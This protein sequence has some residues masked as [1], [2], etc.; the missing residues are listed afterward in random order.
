MEAVALDSEVVSIICQSLG[1]QPADERRSGRSIEAQLLD[2]LRGKRMLLIIDN[3]EHLLHKVGLLAK[4]VHTAPNVH[5]LVTSRQKLGLQS[6]RLYALEGLRYPEPDQTDISAQQLLADYSAAALFAASARRTKSDFQLHDE[7]VPSLVRLCHLVEG[8]PLA[9]ELAAGWTNVLSV[10]DITVEIEQGLPF[11]EGDLHDLPERHRS[12]EAVFNVTWRRMPKD[13]QTIFAQLCVFRGGFSRQAAANVVGANLRQLAL[14]ANK[15]LI[16]YNRELDRY[17]IHRLLRQSGVAKLVRDPEAEKRVRDRHCAYYCAALQRW[18]VL[19]K[20]PTQLETLVKMDI[21]SPNV[22]SAWNFAVQTG[23]F[24]LIDQGAGALGRFYSWRRRYYE[25]ENA[26]R[27]AEQALT[28]ALSATSEGDVRL[29]IKRTWAKI[30]IWQ[31]V[32][33]Q[34]LQA[35][36]LV[37]RALTALNDPNMAAVDARRE[38]AFALLRAGDLAFKS[39][40]QDSKPF[41]QQSLSLYQAL[42]DNWETAQVLIALAWVAAHNGAL[43]ETHQLGKEALELARAA[44][45]CKLMADVLWLLGTLAIL[46]GDVEESSRLLGDSLDIRKLLGDRITD[47]AS[48]PLDLGMTLTWIGRMAEADEVRQ[49]T[50]SFYKELGQPEQI[51]LAHVRLA[52]SKI[53]VDQV[54][55]IAHHARIGLELSCQVGSQRGVGLALWLLGSYSL[56]TGELDQA[57]STIQESLTALRNVEGSAEVGWVL[58]TYAAVVHQQGLPD[59]AKQYICAALQTASGVL[60]LITL[61]F[62]L[63]VYADLLLDEDQ[64]SAALEMFALLNRYPLVRNSPSWQF[65]MMGHAWTV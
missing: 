64:D 33:C 47:I 35:N 12:M 41:Y 62:G 58:G 22:R 31:S 34:R 6:E 51:A 38:R 61:L 53:H 4:I 16:Q 19:L 45:D 46:E 28:R 27:L 48:G 37:R 50:L 49:E 2:Y 60:G 25:G 9:L 1:F 7:E 59:I 56:I 57:A 10:N 36:D 63:T 52:T 18:D 40:G 3:F 30:Q 32:F 23:Q 29:Q 42:G 54:E 21:E 14:L 43:E 11:M 15:A 24:T 26:D 55:A 65:F 20:G 39:D 5:L 17:Q 13:E 44:G 8:L